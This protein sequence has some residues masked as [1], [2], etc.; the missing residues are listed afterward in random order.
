MD[1]S[2]QVFTGKAVGGSGVTPALP[3]KKLHTADIGLLIGLFAALMISIGILLSSLPI[4]LAAQVTMD[5]YQQS[6]GKAFGTTT[7]LDI[8]DETAADGDKII[9]PYS[10]G[11]YT[12]NVYNN[13][14]SDPLPYYLKITE[15]NPENVPI[16]ISLKKNGEYIYGGADESDMCTVMGF[17]MDE[18]LLEGRVTDTYTLEWTWVTYTDK[19]DTALGLRAANGEELTYTIKISATGSLYVKDIDNDG[20]TGGTETGAARGGGT[21]KTGDDMNLLLWIAVLAVAAV[22]IIILLL[23][24]RRRKE[25]EDDN[26]Q[27]P[28]KTM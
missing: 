21:A 5:V 28:P 3:Y 10:S 24:R 20:D 15:E 27:T 6:D 13:S 23:Y 19:A 26:H 11:S 16:R 18:I 22:V 7:S 4:S 17:E 14:D 2:E 25:D 8:F 12:F 9:H 1:N